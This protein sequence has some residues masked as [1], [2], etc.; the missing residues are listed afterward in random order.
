MS[1]DDIRD[2]RQILF[3]HLALAILEQGRPSTI[4][5]MDGG[6]GCMYRGDNGCKCV[7]GHAIPDDL[8]DRSLEGNRIDAILLTEYQNPAFSE[9]QAQLQPHRQMLSSM[10][11]EHDALASFGADSVT[12][13]RE[14]VKAMKRVA[15]ANWLSADV[16]IEAAY[17]KHDIS[18]ALR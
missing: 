5:K 4:T 13:R 3:D 17:K 6:W 8:Y 15:A 7:V 14:W 1:Y 2:A 16:V 18:V 12:F 9:W 11:F 10:Q